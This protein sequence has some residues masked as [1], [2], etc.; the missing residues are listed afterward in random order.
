[1][2]LLCN[3]LM[4]LAC[5][6]ASVRSG[7]ASLCAKLAG[8]GVAVEPLD[9]AV[10]RYGVGPRLEPASCQPSFLRRR[11]IMCL[12]ALR[13]T[14]TASAVPKLRCHQRSCFWLDAR[15]RE[16]ANVVSVYTFRPPFLKSNVFQSLKNWPVNCLLYNQNFHGRWVCVFLA[17]F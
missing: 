8:S 11:R 3:D 6:F 10:A 15:S 1:M 4:G 14:P 12:A 16:C 2:G 13:R 17:W 5:Q 7:C 9:V